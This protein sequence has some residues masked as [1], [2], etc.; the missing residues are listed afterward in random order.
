MGEVVLAEKVDIP[1]VGIFGRHI[2]VADEC[3]LRVGVGVQPAVDVGAQL[4]HPLHFV[5]H[6]WVG[7]SAPV[8]H[9]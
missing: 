8:R 9:V 6:V 7:E 1:H 5:C 3:E 2:P 4:A